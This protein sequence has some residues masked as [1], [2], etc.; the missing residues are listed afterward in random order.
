MLTPPTGID[1]LNHK[2]FCT[3]LSKTL[4]HEEDIGIIWNF[5][6]LIN[7]TSDEFILWYNLSDNVRP[8]WNSWR[9][10]LLGKVFQVKKLLFHF[11][12]FGRYSHKTSETQ[13]EINEN[14]DMISAYW[15]IEVCLNDE[16]CESWGRSGITSI[17]NGIRAGQKIYWGCLEVIVNPKIYPRY[18]L[19]CC[20]YEKYIIYEWYII[21]DIFLIF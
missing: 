1:E 12:H 8:T 9:W 14:G 19:I 7:K 21:F 10:V 15:Y 2:L 20:T 4:Y 13:T 11:V 17:C 16:K 5:S 6:F 3:S 18:V